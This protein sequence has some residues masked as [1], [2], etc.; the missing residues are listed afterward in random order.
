MWKDLDLHLS[1]N[2]RKKPKVSVVTIASIHLAIELQVHLYPPAVGGKCG[3]TLRRPVRS[4]ID[5]VRLNTAG[6]ARAREHQPSGLAAD[7]DAPAAVTAGDL[8]AEFP[9]RRS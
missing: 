5:A 4:D 8:R 9:A 7:L 6:P 1:P 2:F 3:K